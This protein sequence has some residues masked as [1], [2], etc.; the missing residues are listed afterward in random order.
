LGRKKVVVDKRFGVSFRVLPDR[1]ERGRTY[2]ADMWVIRADVETNDEQFKDYVLG[3]IESWRGSGSKVSTSIRHED[4]WTGGTQRLS[5]GSKVT[6]GAAGVAGPVEETDEPGPTPLELEP[7]RQVSLDRLPSEVS[8]PLYLPSPAPGDAPHVTLRPRRM[9]SDDPI[10]VTITY[11]VTED[12]RHR[13]NVWVTLSDRRQP[14]LRD[15]Q[16]FSIDDVEVCE[17][18]SGG[19]YRCKLRTVKGDTFVHIESTAHRLLEEVLQ[20]ARTLAPHPG[21]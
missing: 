8:F 11:G 16:W 9:H 1:R 15:D 10:A 6:F 17:D 3:D 14:E 19:Y 21:S 4:P 2:A 13:G 20:I 12:E 5:F 7:T 18:R